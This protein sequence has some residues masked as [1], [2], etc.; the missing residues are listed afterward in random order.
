LLALK[1]GGKKGEKG[2]GKGERKVDHGR[3]SYDFVLARPPWERREGKGSERS[4]SEKGERGVV[5]PPL[6]SCRSAP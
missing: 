4:L 1:R 6:L 2:L 5:G 3:I